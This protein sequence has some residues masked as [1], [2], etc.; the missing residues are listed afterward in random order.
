[1]ARQICKTVY[2]F[3]ELSD[4]AKKK[5][6]EHWNEH[7]LDYEWWDAVYEDAKEIGKLMGITITDI[8]FSGFSSQGDGACFEGSYEYAKGSIKA[9]KDYA[10]KDEN[11]HSIVRDLQNIQR[12]SFYG[13][14][15]S[16]KQSGHYSHEYCTDISVYDNRDNAPYEVDSQTEEAL[17]DTLRDF[18][19]WIYRQLEKEYDWLTSDEQ[20][21]ET[22]VA[23]EY[24]FDEHGNWA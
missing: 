11:L 9:V 21:S 5:A 17:A 22:L 23:N 18:M 7:G 2:K 8:Y 3:E 13:L 4:A 16:V 14:S 1:M 19:R 12:R 10:P 15:A 20:V 6:I 24:E